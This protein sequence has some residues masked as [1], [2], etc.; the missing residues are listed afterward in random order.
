MFFQ[1]TIAKFRVTPVASKDVSDDTRKKS[2][3]AVISFPKGRDGPPVAELFANRLAQV[4]RGPMTVVPAEQVT[5]LAVDLPLRSEAKRRAALP[6]ALEDRLGAP[7]DTVHLALAPASGTKTRIAAVVARSV[8]AATDGPVIPELWAVPPPETQGWAVWRIGQRV[9]VRTK[10]GMGFAVRADQLVAVWRRAGRPSV[11]SYGAA[12]PSEIAAQDASDN[13]PAVG[14]LFDLRQGAFAV[15]QGGWARTGYWAALSA[16]LAVIGH[17]ALVVADLRILQRAADQA[18]AQAQA[19]LAEPLPGVDLNL[20]V[21]RILAR[22]APVPE[23][24]PQSAFLPLL[25]EVTDLA[26]GVTVRRLAWRAGDDLVLEVEARD[27]VGLQALDLALTAGGLRVQSGAA[28]A[29]DVGAR[30]ELRVSR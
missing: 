15:R 25:A 7:L 8:M 6:F 24:R 9:V 21:E 10:E 22:L 5:L 27:F 30:A 13:P 17:L 23:S 1:R 4:I 3:N 28:T 12:V 19:A 29:S 11:V 20:G 18:R 16:G 26:P 2:E 14:P